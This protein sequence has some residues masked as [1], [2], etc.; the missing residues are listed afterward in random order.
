MLDRENDAVAKALSIPP[1]LLQEILEGNDD[2]LSGL[3]RV[4]LAYL[5]E[6]LTERC[7]DPS[8]SVNGAASVMEI[9]RK[10]AAGEKGGMGSGDNQPQVIINI[11]RARD[12]A[13]SDAIEINSAPTPPLEALDAL[14]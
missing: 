7:A 14:D 12:R 5:M 3:A 6:K 4:Q 8:T 13:G 2:A 11:T 10:M 1:A 9:L